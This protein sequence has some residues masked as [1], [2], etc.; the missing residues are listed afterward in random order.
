MRSESSREGLRCT[1]MIPR[2]GAS[3]CLQLGTEEVSGYPESAI[4]AGFQLYVRWTP[5]FNRTLTAFSQHPT[6]GVC[7]RPRIEGFP[8]G[9][10]SRAQGCDQ[11]R[12]GSGSGER[13]C[14]WDWPRCRLQ[15]APLTSLQAMHQLSNQQAAAHTPVDFDATVTFYRSYE[16]TLFVQ[17]GDTAIYVQPAKTFSLPP[18]DRVHVHGD[19]A[20]E[21]P[22]F[23]RQC[24]RRCPWPR[25]LC[26]HRRWSTFDALINARFDC[27]FVRRAR[28]GCMSA[29]I[30]MSSDRPEHHDEGCDGWRYRRNRDRRQRIPAPCHPFSTPRSRFPARFQA[31]STARWR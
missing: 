8:P 28:H 25:G 7:G 10:C 3:A 18:G 6:D 24:R 21:L 14:S 19:H 1:A 26:P 11:A 22:A 2:P 23:Y 4:N 16:S 29:D 20:G 12:C 30:T 9:V 31:A 15:A 13:C 5:R 17:D 27:R